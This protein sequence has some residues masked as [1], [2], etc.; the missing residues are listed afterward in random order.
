LLCFL[1]NILVS[2]ITPSSSSSALIIYR[3]FKLAFSDS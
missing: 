2:T 1:D 3:P